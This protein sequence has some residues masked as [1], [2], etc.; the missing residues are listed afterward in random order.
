MTAQLSLVYAPDPVFKRKSSPVETVDDTI[1]DLVDGMFELLE[2]EKAVGLGAPMVGVLK[3]I[4]IVD[5]HENGV[6]TPY[7]FINPE[8]IW[9][10][11]TTQTFEEASLC[12]P[13][14]SAEITRPDTVELH[15]LDRNGNARKLKAEG[16]F[17]AV[18]Q[19]ELDYLDGITFPDH[20]SRLK[21]DRLL[22]K[23]KKHVRTHPPHV[24]SI[25]C[26]H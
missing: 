16:F 2:R 3:R 1:R 21:R 8:I 4:A 7:T 9:H 12:F 19:H 6:S 15:Y 22:A 11:Q 25:H 24:H 5:L 23:M 20:L 13:G 14:I 26:N 10:S 18:I 17:A